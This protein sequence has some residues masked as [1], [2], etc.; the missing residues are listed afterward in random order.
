MMIGI[1]SFK[2]GVGKTFIALNLAYM[3]SKE[4]GVCVVD[5]DLV[6]P[7][8]YSFFECKAYLNDFL[9]K[10]AELE[11][12]IV[13]ISDSLYAIL[14]SPDPNAI[15]RELKKS[16]KEE[17]KTLERL[18]DLKRMLIEF[19]YVILDTH[20]G[21]SY[22][23]INSLILSDVVFL[24]LRPDNIDIDGTKS[25]LKIVENLSKPVYGVINRDDGR[26]IHLPIEIVA[27]IPCSCEVSMDEPFF[28]ET[29]KDHPVTESINNLSKFVLQLR[30]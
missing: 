9:Y 3:L 2:G 7:S 13:K 30:R 10:K 8:L 26:E 20:P 19:D 1:H 23:S 18:L 29:F 21:L 12:C 14:A 22:S 11:D 15:K 6:A 28:V 27:R 5:L 25:M 4:R 24:I 17:M 16:D